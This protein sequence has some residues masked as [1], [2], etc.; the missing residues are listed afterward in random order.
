MA[1]TC[2]V[3]GKRTRST[4]SQSFKKN[5]TLWVW[6][7]NLTSKVAATVFDTPWIQKLCSQIS[8]ELRDQVD[9]IGFP[10]K[11]TENKEKKIR[12]LDYA[13]G[14]GLASRVSLQ[15]LTPVETR[16]DLECRRLWRLTSTQ[17]AAS[18]YPPEW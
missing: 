7:N 1:M 17:S 16:I 8:D 18:T 6:A 10:K 13:C 11:N 3:L 9:W 12:M 14:N 5:I 4:S 15:W 2:R